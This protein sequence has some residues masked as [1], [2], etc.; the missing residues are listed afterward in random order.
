MINSENQP[1]ENFDIILPEKKFNLDFLYIKIFSN[2]KQIILFIFVFIITL[3]I[4]HFV[5]IIYG[6]NSLKS[7]NQNYL[8]E[9]KKSNHTKIELEILYSEL[10]KI[11]NETEILNLNKEKNIIKLKE[12]FNETLKEYSKLEKIL[13]DLIIEYNNKLE[14]NLKYIFF[15][16][17]NNLMKINLKKS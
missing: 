16:T 2:K 4:T 10:N 1:F 6:N 8:S 12:T 13:N 3:V 15:L 9:I 14:K 17:K 7:V 5:I 11:N